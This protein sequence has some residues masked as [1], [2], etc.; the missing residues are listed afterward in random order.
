MGR[1]YST[2]R[3]NS[4]TCRVLVGKSKGRRPHEIPRRRWDNNIKVG[5]K[6]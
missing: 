4:G 3:T 1:A 6:N 2:Y 5:P